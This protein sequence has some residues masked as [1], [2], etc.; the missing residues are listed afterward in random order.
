M[1]E[2]GALS[3]QN[4]KICLKK[5]VKIIH[6]EEVERRSTTCEEYDCIRCEKQFEIK[7][8]LTEH[9]KRSHCRK[10]SFV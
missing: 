2:D 1:A 9:M 3:A 7:Q 5:H 8:D 6:A 10:E 4:V